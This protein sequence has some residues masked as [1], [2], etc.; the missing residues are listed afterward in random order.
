MMIIAA[1]SG[2]EMSLRMK[3]D[4][5]KTLL[6]DMMASIWPRTRAMST[7]WYCTRAGTPSSRRTRAVASRFCCSWN[8]KARSLS[9]FSAS[10]AV[11]LLWLLVDGLCRLFHALA[12]RAPRAPRAPALR[13]ALPRVADARP[14]PHA[15]AAVAAEAHVVVHCLLLR[16]ALSRRT[17][18]REQRRFLGGVQRPQSGQWRA[19]RSRAA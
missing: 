1:F 9:C 11:A 14:V 18:H 5:T 6:R 8:S 17:A 7:C 10:L 13:A 3:P 16:S 2:V 19:R 15:P 12:P 4:A